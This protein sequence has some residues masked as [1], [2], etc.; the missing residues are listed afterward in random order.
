MNTLFR[1]QRIMRLG[2][3]SSNEQ[4]FAAGLTQELLK[5]AVTRASQT[6]LSNTATDADTDNKKQLDKR[7]YRSLPSVT[8]TS[9]AHMLWQSV[10]REDDTIIDA[11]CGNGHDALA[12]AQMLF[13]NDNNKNYSSK[14]PG[15][16]VCI[17]V[18]S[19]AVERTRELLKEKLGNDLVTSRVELIQGSHD[20]LPSEYK[21]NVGLVCYNLGWLPGSPETKAV[22]TELKSTLNSLADAALTLRVGGILSVM[23]Y[24]GTSLDEAE[25]VTAFCEALALLTAR[26]EGAAQKRVD[27][28]AKH[29]NMMEARDIVQHALER[30]IYNGDSFQ[31]WRVFD[32]RPLGRP[33]SPILVTATRIK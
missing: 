11:T 2:S 22:S 21:N 8:P 10:I 24:P 26:D 19:I 12:A 27:E 25:A 33:I 31:T 17:D 4:Q 30:V 32:H 18:Q 3:S 28:L 23:T 14:A 16:L 5:N 15:K 20:P 9:L 6:L 7:T 1:S 13:T 29:N